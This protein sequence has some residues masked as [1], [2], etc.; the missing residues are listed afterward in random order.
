MFFKIY[1]SEEKFRCD[2]EAFNQKQIDR[3]VRA[4][5]EC[6]SDEQYISPMEAR[7]HLWQANSD[8]AI[9]NIGGVLRDLKTAREE[10]F[11]LDTWDKNRKVRIDN[12][13][14]KVRDFLGKLLRKPMKE[15]D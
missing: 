11:G 7:K 2:A 12:K 14:R 4:L 6:T 15:R 1:F 5:C 9:N 13:L 8:F 10:L 3:T